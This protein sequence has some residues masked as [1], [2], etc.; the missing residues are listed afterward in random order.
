MACGL[1][2]S[3]ASLFGC[4]PFQFG[5]L[6]KNSRTMSIFFQ[7]LIVSS[8]KESLQ[9]F[10]RPWA[11]EHEPIR[12]LVDAVNVR[13]HLIHFLPSFQV[14]MFLVFWFADSVRQ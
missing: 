14:Q 5:P 4:A 9:H 13:T 3:K 2:G 6:T 11:H 12:D 10:K 1:E 7:G 8:R